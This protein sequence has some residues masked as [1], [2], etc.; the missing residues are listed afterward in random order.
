M[1]LIPLGAAAL[2]GALALAPAAR[3][4]MSAAEREAFRAEV[5][6]YLLENPEVLMEA[7]TALEQ[8][9]QL[10]Q[11]NAD[12][13]RLQD[14]SS[15]IYTDPASWAGGNLQG[16]ITVVEFIDYRCGYCRKAN[17]EV[18]ELVASD[19]NI[20]FVLKEYP[21]L[22][23]ESVLASRFAISVLQIAGP[24]PYK[25]VHD[26]LIAFRGDITTEALGRLAD[27]MELD[28][29]AILAHMDKDE[30]TAV[31]AANHKLAET[32]EISGTP[33]FVVDR[34]MVR[35]YVPLDGMRQIVEGQRKG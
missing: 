21:I 25:A 33:T 9:Q 2:A 16:D 15:E 11:V 10:D 4:E 34:T 23:E 24:E 29:A 5:R 12:L 8:R 27:E 32:L 13:A 7:F 6:A 3:A 14:H 30:V 28:R 20:R 19:G 35:G 22:G 26:K 17:A 1:K 18:E 31:I